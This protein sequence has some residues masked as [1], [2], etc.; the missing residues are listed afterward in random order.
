MT[1]G[2]WVMMVCACGGTL[3]TYIWCMIRV[4]R[5]G[6]PGRRVQPEDGAHG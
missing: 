2:G 1:L 4:L 5:S 3:I 6:E